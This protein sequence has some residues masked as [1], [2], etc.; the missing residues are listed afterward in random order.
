MA[1]PSSCQQIGASLSQFNAWRAP[2]HRGRCGAADTAAKRHTPGESARAPDQQ[3]CTRN[4][5]RSGPTSRSTA[6]TGTGDRRRG[7]RGRS[8]SCRRPSSTSP[9]QMR[10]ATTARSM[11][12]PY[13]LCP[14]TNAP[15]PRPPRKTRPARMA[16][17]MVGA[18]FFPRRRRR[19]LPIGFLRSSRRTSSSTRCHAT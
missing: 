8:S 7:R 2:V 12:S 10:S 5:A 4:P 1:T 18:A 19:R 9:S 17:G 13:R 16:A 11:R 14:R 15:S 3:C 6:A